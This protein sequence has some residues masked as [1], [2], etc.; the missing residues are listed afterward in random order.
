[1]L[2]SYPAAGQTKKGP[3]SLLTHV[4]IYRGIRFKL[5]RHAQLK[6]ICVI[7]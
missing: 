7:Y 4:W 1:M 2:K 3:C 5:R 6:V